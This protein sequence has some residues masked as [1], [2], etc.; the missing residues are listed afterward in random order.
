M[1]LC[2][3]YARISFDLTVS[4]SRVPKCAIRP[5]ARFAGR[6]VPLCT[7]RDS[8]RRFRHQRICNILGNMY[9]DET[10]VLR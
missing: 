4:R 7:K 2:I 5:G 9:V 10:V 6:L 3:H 1:L 8:F